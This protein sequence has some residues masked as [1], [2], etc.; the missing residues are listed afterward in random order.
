LSQPSRALP[1]YRVVYSELCREATRQLLARAVAKGRITEVARAVGDVERRLQWIPLDFGE[2]LKDFVHLG[3][4]EYIGVLAP[5]VVK[6]SV[7]EDRRI[8]Y[9]ALPFGLLPRSG[10]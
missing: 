3:I 9:V 6:F 5:L 2:P 10:L 4:K 7:D 1:P 8:V